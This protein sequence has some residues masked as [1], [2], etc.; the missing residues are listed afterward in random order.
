MIGKKLFEGGRKDATH[1]METLFNLEKKFPESLIPSDCEITNKALKAIV[2]AC[3]HCTTLQ[4]V[5]DALNEIKPD[6]V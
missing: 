1:F 6:I 2:N 5:E 4:E 3:L